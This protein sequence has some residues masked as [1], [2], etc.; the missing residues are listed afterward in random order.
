[1][2]TWNYP[3]CISS[4]GKENARQLQLATNL[5][6]VS[7]WEAE[8]T[9]WEKWEGK[10]TSK[11]SRKL[12]PQGPWPFHARLCVFWSVSDRYHFPLLKIKTPAQW[13]LPKEIWWELLKYLILS[14]GKKILHFSTFRLLLQPSNQ[15]YFSLGCI[16][17]ANLPGLS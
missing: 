1:M 7:K 12:I 6:L 11:L 14:P 15:H 3:F 9:D 16:L 8:F 4:Q 13:T 17:K 2:F 10:G 5:L